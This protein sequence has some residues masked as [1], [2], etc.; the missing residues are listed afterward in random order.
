[1]GNE[2]RNIKFRRGNLSVSENLKKKTETE[3]GEGGNWIK[4]QRR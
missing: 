1:M 2:G 4:R 3:K